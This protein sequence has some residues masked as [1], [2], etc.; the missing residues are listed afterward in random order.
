MHFSSLDVAIIFSDEAC[1]RHLTNIPSIILQ[2]LNFL[3][4]LKSNY[5]NDFTIDFRRQYE[6][7]IRTEYIKLWHLL[8]HK[9]TYNKCV[10]C[11][12]VKCIVTKTWLHNNRRILYLPTNR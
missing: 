12:A 6:R 1:Q 9:V 8:L 7:N 3:K 2:K 4:L 11:E 5:T 10:A